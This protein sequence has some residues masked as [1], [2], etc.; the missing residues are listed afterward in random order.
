MSRWE[1]LA[2]NALHALLA[3]TGGVYFYMKYVLRTDDPFAV[4]NH[5]WQS[6]TLA[7]HV[8]IAPLGMM[9]F[10]VVFRSH[11]LK[12][13]SMQSR[14]ARRS[15]WTSLLSF[16]AM[17]TSGYLLQVLAEPTWLRAMVV[18]HVATSSVFILGYS[19]HLFVGWRVPRA[20]LNGAGD[21]GLSRSPLPP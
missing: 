14:S 1:A 15:G 11:T 17:A 19:V 4:V 8:V 16:G 5:P 2:F 7:A 18:I 10:G 20:T 9:I 3:A 6:A 13:L 21:P 12:K